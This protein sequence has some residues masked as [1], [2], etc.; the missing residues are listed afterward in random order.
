[1]KSVTFTS[2]K[3]KL[4]GKYERKLEKEEAEFVAAYEELQAE[5]RELESLRNSLRPWKAE[6]DS[7]E[8]SAK[9]VDSMIQR[10]R[11]IENLIF[12]GPSPYYPSE[13]LLEQQTKCLQLQSENLR[14]IM[15]RQRTANTYIDDAVTHCQK[16][17]KYLLDAKELTSANMT[18]DAI[19]LDCGKEYNT[20]KGQQKIELCKERVEA[21]C[22]IYPELR[23]YFPEGT[24]TMPITKPSS[25]I[26]EL[27]GNNFK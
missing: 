9:L 19:I 25:F 22:T 16:A 10:L 21:A 15:Y 5:Q 20:D 17:I 13:D 24:F 6:S 7:L 27:F 2:L 1:M 8:V 4:V 12:D 18:L 11:E 3:A 26:D 14:S 23:N